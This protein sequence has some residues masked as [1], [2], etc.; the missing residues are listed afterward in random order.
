MRNGERAQTGQRSV[1]KPMFFDEGED[2][3]QGADCSDNDD[4]W[5]QRVIKMTFLAYPYE[6][7]PLS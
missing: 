5:K 6:N 3:Y 1:Q 2:D 7:L 4:K